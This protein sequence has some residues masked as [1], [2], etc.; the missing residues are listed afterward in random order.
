MSVL[1]SDQR[2]LV[3]KTYFQDYTKKPGPTFLAG[4]TLNFTEES[5]RSK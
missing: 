3:E 5:F 1:L 4:E 2:L